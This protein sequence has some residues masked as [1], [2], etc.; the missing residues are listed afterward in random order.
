MNKKGL[1][2]TIWAILIICFIFFIIGIITLLVVLNTKAE[3]KQEE[4]LNSYKLS[5]YLKATDSYGTQIGGEYLILNGEKITGKLSKDSYTEIL[6]V[7]SNSSKLILISSNGFYSKLLNKSFTQDEINNNISKVVLSLYKIGKL[8]INNSGKLI[9][10][11]NTIILNVS[12]KDSFNKLEVC[13]SWT[14][15]ILSLNSEPQLICKSNWVNISGVY[16]CEGVEENC[17]SVNG[18]IC[19]PTQKEIP[20]RLKGKVDKCFY[21]GNNLM[22][23]NTLIYF[24]VKA[25]NLNSL[26]EIK[27]TIMDNE[28][29]YSDGFK[30]FSEL[31][32]NVGADDFIYEVKYEN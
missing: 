32:G 18:L 27:F 1:S 8:S 17:D 3:Q 6:N 20:S 9:N 25:N 13:V 10:G 2:G 31:N 12:T 14:S 15:G 23:S 11:D 4:Q 5:L 16:S 19:Y 29:F 24:N 7:S 26:D 22:N 28:I 21:Y 30:Y